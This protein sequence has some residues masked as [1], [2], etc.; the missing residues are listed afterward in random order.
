M[1]ERPYGAC[2]PL[3]RPPA[4]A[5]WEIALDVLDYRE[6]LQTLAE[7]LAIG[8]NEGDTSPSV[9]LAHIQSEFDRLHIAKHVG[10]VN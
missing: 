2:N 8:L 6:A 4:R 7:A 5:L 3:E 10:R 9:F 1:S